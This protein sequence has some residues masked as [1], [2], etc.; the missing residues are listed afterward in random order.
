M[1]R[2]KDKDHPKGISLKL[3]EEQDDDPGF[4]AELRASLK[5]I[6]PE[7]Y[8]QIRETITQL[9]RDMMTQQRAEKTSPICQKRRRNRIRSERAGKVRSL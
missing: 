2:T 8:P 3:V 9:A 6:P 4:R 1:S 5:Q 7:Y